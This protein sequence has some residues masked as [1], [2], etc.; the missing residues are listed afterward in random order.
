MPNCGVRARL[1]LV[2]KL[3]AGLAELDAHMAIKHAE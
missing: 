2:M 3:G 1:I